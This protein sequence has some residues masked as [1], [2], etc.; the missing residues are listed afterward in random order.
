LENQR[1]DLGALVAVLQRLSMQPRE[2]LILGYQS[3]QDMVLSA[4]LLNY[5]LPGIQ[6]KAARLK[7]ELADIQSLR[8][9][10][11]EQRREIATAAESLRGVREGIKRLVAQ[12]ASLRRVTEEDRAEANRRVE[13]L[14]RQAEDLRE[15]RALA[16][17][18]RSLSCGWSRRIKDF[19]PAGASAVVAAAAVST[20]VARTRIITRPARPRCGLMTARR[21]L[22]TYSRL[23]RLLIIE[24]Q[25]YHTLAGLGRTTWCGANG[26]CRKQLVLWMLIGEHGWL[27]RIQALSKR[28]PSPWRSPYEQVE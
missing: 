15:L 21:C 9:D 23:W 20:D 18:R 28:L 11:A 5:A 12:K 16:G 26:A 6:A 13:E 17:G 1:S 19:P 22:R 2:A 7:Q 14:A 27:C 4:E 10:A 25:L 3:P 24:H 8:E